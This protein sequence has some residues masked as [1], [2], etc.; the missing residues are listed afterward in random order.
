MYGAYNEEKT[1]H[2]D[3]LWKTDFGSLWR[4]Y[5]FSNDALFGGSEVL[6]HYTNSEKLSD[7][8]KYV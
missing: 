6:Q 5:Y 1:E 8:Q 4:N 2:S 3:G 7:M